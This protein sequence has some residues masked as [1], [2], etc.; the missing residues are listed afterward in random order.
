M[1]PF[2]HAQ[3][4]SIRVK[5]NVGLKEY[6]EWRILDIGGP[7][8]TATALY[9]AG[10]VVPQEDMALVAPLDDIWVK[11]LIYCND[12]WSYDK[13]LRT[14]QETN[15]E[16]ITKTSA[17]CSSVQAFSSVSIIMEKA[18]ITAS[19]AKRVL[20]F[21]QREMEAFHENVASEVLAK[22]AT[23]EVQRYIKILEYQMSGN[24][25]WTSQ[26]LRYNFSRRQA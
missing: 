9:C 2:M 26:T 12:A 8:I 1:A 22:K 6:L 23:P 3:T 14:A 15:P 19:A 11:H 18:G 25:L 10:L 24:E 16:A 21:L 20:V 17:D 4:A 13:E 5:E 7:L